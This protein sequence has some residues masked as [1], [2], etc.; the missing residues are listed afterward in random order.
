MTF[1]HF[2]VKF[3]GQ[4]LFQELL[5]PYHNFDTIQTDKRVLCSATHNCHYDFILTHFLS[6]KLSVSSM[7]LLKPLLFYETQ[8]FSVQ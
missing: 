2:G 7:C 8:E 6:P 5:F 1:M 3:K 4:H